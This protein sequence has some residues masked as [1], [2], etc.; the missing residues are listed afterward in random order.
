MK[1]L[2]F[3]A[4]LALLAGEPVDAQ[5]MN[6]GDRVRVWSKNAM[7]REMHV[8]I[9]SV[10]S[11]ILFSSSPPL[12]LPVTDINRIEYPI[13]RSRREGMVYGAKAGAFSGVAVGVVAAFLVKRDQQEA[14]AVMALTVPAGA[15]IGTVLGATLGSAVPGK[16]WR[17]VPGAPC[18]R[19]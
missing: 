15:I 12:R 11:G 7:L 9:D 14:S 17:C 6:H 13:P 1:T 5:D 18:N 10:H 4:A 2:L 19:M 3:V 16:H 8:T